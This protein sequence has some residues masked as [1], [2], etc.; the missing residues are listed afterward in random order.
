VK[1]E[2]G[3]RSAG[4]KSK[5]HVFSLQEAC[6]APEVRTGGFGVYLR[7]LGGEK[8]PQRATRVR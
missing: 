7:P 1:V 5:Q 8:H 4:R 3:Q 2:P 6:T